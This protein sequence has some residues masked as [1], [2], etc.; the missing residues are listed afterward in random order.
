MARTDTLKGD[1]GSVRGAARTLDLLEAF[2]AEGRTLSLSQLAKLLEMPVSSCHQLVGTLEARGYLY[3]IGRRKEI[4]PSGKILGIARAI[5]SN[6]PWMTRAVPQLQRLRTC[7]RET[8]L[9]GKRQD[10]YV[11][12]L[13]VEEGTEAIRFTATLGDRKPLHVSVLGRAL[14]GGL[15]APLRDSLL[16][17]LDNR[18]RATPLA[19]DMAEVVRDLEIGNERGWHVHQGGR[20]FDVMA[21]GVSFEI[22]GETFAIGIAGPLPRIAQAKDRLAAALLETQA[23]ISG[24]PETGGAPPAAVHR[25]A[26]GEF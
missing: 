10:R 12:Y 3:T 14:L 8:V 17:D 20:E 1:T 5:V 11:I 24:M 7:T 6:D 2:A 22:S 18:Y 21:I 4:Y 9:L 19:L 13:A 26:A 16:R 25:S 15:D 23:I